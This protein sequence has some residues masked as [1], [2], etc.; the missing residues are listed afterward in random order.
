MKSLITLSTSLWIPCNFGVLVF[1]FVIEV[2]KIIL[3]SFS[4]SNNV[5]VLAFASGSFHPSTY[6]PK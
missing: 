3:S 1:S 2:S 4:S 6:N 5:T